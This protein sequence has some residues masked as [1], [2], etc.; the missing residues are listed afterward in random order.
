[1]FIPFIA[2]E[3]GLLENKGLLVQRSL[4]VRVLVLNRLWQAVNTCTAKRA[5]CLLYVGHAQVV[6]AYPRQ[7][8]YST[9]DFHS[10]LSLSATNGDAEVIDTI[11][12]KV[13]VPKIIVLTLFDRFPKKAVKLTRQNLFERDSYTCQY[14]ERKL[15]RQELNIDHVVPRDLG[16]ASTWENLVCSCVPCNTRKG[17]LLIHQVGMRLRRKPSAPH[18]QPA[19]N[20]S[21]NGS[22]HESWLNFVDPSRWLAHV[23]DEEC[24]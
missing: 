3:G 5:L 20:L 16:G 6:D 12:Y 23:A 21:H 19:V 24:R 15:E 17:N 1:M 14:C 9:H 13:R 10:W 8:H 2:R 4:N 7:N 22:I 11:S 18:W